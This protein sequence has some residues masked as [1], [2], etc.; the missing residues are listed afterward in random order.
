MSDKVLVMKLYER[1]SAKGTRYFAG[2]LGA[3]RVV[4][5]LDHKAEADCPVW[6]VYVQDGGV[7]KPREKAAPRA[8]QQAARDFARGQQAPLNEGLPF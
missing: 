3:A 7:R 5:F 4:A 1:I 8:E 2:R 6:N